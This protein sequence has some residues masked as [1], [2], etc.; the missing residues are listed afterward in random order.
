QAAE[1]ARANEPSAEVRRQAEELEVAL[2]GEESGARRDR[3]LL[4]ALL[5]GRGPREGQRFHKGHR[6]LGLAEP[7]ADEQFRAAFRAWGL[8]VDATPTAEAARRLRARPAAVVA[9]V[10]AA[11]DEWAAERRRQGPAG[12]EGGRRLALLATALEEGGG[13]RR[14]QLREMLSR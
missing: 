11:L 3:A 7:S 12:A 9:E 10:V 13:P 14:R 1:L 8:D 6:G 5:E 2:A 4:T